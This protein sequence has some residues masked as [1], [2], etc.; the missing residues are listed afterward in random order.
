M[1]NNLSEQIARIRADYRL[2]SLDETDTGDEPLAFFR[3]WFQEAQ[4]AGISEVNAMTLA[5]AN[6]WGTPSARTVLLKGLDDEGFVFF[7]NYE[8]DK[9]TQIA[10][11]NTVALLFFWKELER[12]VRIE[13]VAHKVSSEESDAYFSSRPRGSQISAIASRQSRIVESRAELEAA[14]AALEQ[15]YANQEIPRP[16]NWGGYRVIPEKMEFWQGRSNR[17][18]DRIVF[19]REPETISEQEEVT[20][21]STWEKYRLAP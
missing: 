14:V 5:T 11:E 12:Q 6:I 4:T 13:G 2:A 21:F 17:L 10:E 1:S 19:F 16:D 18:H 15:R 7:T 20:K 9:G 8:S 3:R